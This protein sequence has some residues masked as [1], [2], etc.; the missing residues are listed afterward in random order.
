MPTLL[1]SSSATSPSPGQVC[2][3][4]V[5]FLAESCRRFPPNASEPRWP[6]VYENEWCGEWADQPR[7]T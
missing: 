3:T 4:C 1:N 6:T 7:G 2:A 5:F